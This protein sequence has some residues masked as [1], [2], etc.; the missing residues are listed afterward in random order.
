MTN[1]RAAL[2]AI[3]GLTSTFSL[4]CKSESVAQASPPAGEVRPSGHY[5]NLGVFTP[6]EWERHKSLVPKLAAATTDR[7][8][9]ADGYE[10]KFSGQFKEAG[11]WLD[12]VRRC[13][14]TVRYQVEFETQ[15]GPA[16]LRV[17]GGAGAKEFIRAEFNQLFASRT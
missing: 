17:T 16:R 8:E 11:E 6:V 3:A 13:C 9:L 4:S 2:A 15:T 10:F 7:L 1:A 5:C 12:G 14:P